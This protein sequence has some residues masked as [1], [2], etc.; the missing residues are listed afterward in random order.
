MLALAVG[1]AARGV[2]WRVVVLEHERV[3]LYRRGRLAR[4]LD[5]GVYW[6]AWPAR[7][8]VRV[9]V[10]PR[11]R[12]TAGQEV[13][14]RDGTPVRVTLAV[15]YRVADPIAALARSTAYEEALYLEAQ[16]ALRDLLAGLGL[17][18]L[19]ERR[20]QLATDLG[21]ALVPRAAA[22][23]LQV[24]TAGIKDLTFPA[25]IKEA[26]ARVVEARKAAQAALERARGETAALRHLANTA[27][28]LEANPGL[29][30]LLPRCRRWTMDA[31][32]WCSATR[33]RCSRGPRA[34]PDRTAGD[35]GR[36]ESER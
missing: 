8:L 19:M 4:V 33:E 1:L 16:L 27:R 13:P 10:R 17:E 25:P 32:R 30:T 11:I 24:E 31:T 18:E 28:M 35:E 2:L 5:A 12:A 23:G 15:R 22:L 9:D 20:R 7:R 14:S 3:L 6:I 26:F 36:E 21:A 29:A 34:G